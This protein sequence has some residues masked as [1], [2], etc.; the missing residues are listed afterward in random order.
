M[1]KSTDIFLRE[2][3]SET[4]PI[5]FRTPI[6]FGG[7]VMDKFVL[8]NVTVEAE[9]R[10][11]RRGRG[12]GSMPMASVWAWPSQSVSA[13]DGADAMIDLGRRLADEAGRCA[14][15][16]H[17]LE[18]TADLEQMHES[19]AAEVVRAAGLAEAMPRLAQLVAASPLEAAVHDAYG[20]T[21][22]ENSYNLLGR[23]FIDR[24]LSHFLTDEFAG[25]WLDEFTLRRPKP[26]MPLYHLVGALD[27]LGDGDVSRP[28]GD[29]LPET[30]AEW[31]PYNGL[32]HLKIKLA[33]DD[34]AW[35][36]ARVL[37]VE[38][39]AAEAQAARG[40]SDWRYSAD[41]NEKC[42]NV[43][44]VLDFLN[45]VEEGSPA[46]LRRLQYIEQPTSRDLKA[47]PENRMHRAAAIKP[48]VIDESLVDLES[49][50]L[51][52]E[53]GY[54]GVALKAC[55]GHTGALL[56]A[57]AAQKYGM[58]LCVQDLTC[59][60][61]SFL[62]SASLAARVPGVAAIEGNGRQYCPSGNRGWAERFPTMFNIVDGT[63]GSAALDGPGLGF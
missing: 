49:L 36:V 8:L 42:A 35:D 32:T 58:F 40:C 44:Y 47:N 9:T 41:F 21:L 59:P 28:V 38:R 62:H 52:R 10:D 15:S 27:P 25:L 1:P 54:S 12:F 34:L 11:G 61:A 46:A 2:V 17:P 33:G 24:D 53:L 63:L 7:R 19:A 14:E 22:G 31:I 4:E 18:I 50:R 6:K 29:G 39:V 57:A 20:K 48:V 60:G 56:M 13:D 37:E 30:L 5:E 51:S 26:R 23:E 3:T 45:K 55:K 43:E 16:G